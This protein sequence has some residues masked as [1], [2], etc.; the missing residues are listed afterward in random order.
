MPEYMDS[1]QAADY[2]GIHYQTLRNW[3]ERGLIQAINHS[4]SSKK[5]KWVYTKAECDRARETIANQS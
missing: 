4:N 2:L 1:Y 3:R 5:P